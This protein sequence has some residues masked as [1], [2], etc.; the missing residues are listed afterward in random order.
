MN[1]SQ[2]F[3]NFDRFAEMPDTIQR[4]RRFILDLS[5]R[6]RLVE[7]NPNDKPASEL[8]KQIQA[9]KGALVAKGKRGIDNNRTIQDD[10]IPFP[11]SP[12]M[13]FAR[14]ATIARIEK[15]CTG[16]QKATPGQY[17]L[18]TLAEERAT[19]AEY[20]FDTAAAI[21]P[22]ISSTGHGHASLKRMHYQE[23][24]F[25][26]GNILCAV[27]PFAS[28]V[29]S[30]R[31]L[32]EYLWAYKEPLLVAKMIGTAN[33][34]LTIGKI[35][36]AP[37]PIVSPRSQARL[38]EL[39]TLCDQLEAVQEERERRRD[40][41]VAASLDR[42][43]NGADAQS[44]REHA[45]FHLNHLPLL[46]TR[47]EHIQQ[48][49]QIILN[50]AVR[51]KLAP[52]DPS[53][54]TGSGLLAHIKKLKAQMLLEKPIR[55]QQDVEYST[56]SNEAGF[57]PAWTWAYVDNVA[58]VQGGKRLPKGATF[59]KSP[60]DHIYI[61]VTDMKNGTVNEEDV[62]YIT[63]EVHR[64]IARYTIS[65]NDLY[66]TIAGT[67]GQIGRVPRFFDG[68]NLTEN[69][70]KIVFRGM[71]PD[72]FRMALGS[73]FVQQQFRKKTKQMAQPK[74]A[75]KRILG[76]KFPLPPLAE[77]HRI[78]AK[79]DELMTLCDRLGSQLTTAQTESRRFLETV[80]HK[81]LNGVA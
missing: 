39:I 61:R 71:N 12:E 9:K 37:I 25:A 81:A 57:P 5:L 31:F 7:Q 45:R 74:L 1:D 64:A 35:G 47:P 20:Q 80:L 38:H 49:R 46:T 21:V 58:I 24:K 2:L 8:L 77:Q 60:T 11:V 23:G 52:Q 30:A 78:V 29:I 72:Y 43:N 65:Q 15:G 75:L 3:A 56:P 51:G 44:F 50:L 26:L 54:G 42:L 16:I 70:A 79:V 68:H 33:V 66:I 4:L 6:G 18:V 19:S 34:S 59:S 40:R 76:V 10:E 69:A 62:Q 55:G 22:L 36:E 14:L 67:I 41:L 17:P 32:Y 73:D 63:P 53:E 48:L 27:I 28:E 13:V